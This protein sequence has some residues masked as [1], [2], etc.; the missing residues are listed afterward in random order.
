MYD[1]AL[2]DILPVIKFHQE[3]LASSSSSSFSHS[4]HP[5]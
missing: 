5:I 3:N 2:V 1:N 4:S